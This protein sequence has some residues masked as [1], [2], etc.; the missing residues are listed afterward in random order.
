M[1][2]ICVH[3]QR[4]IQRDI[5]G[6]WATVVTNPSLQRNSPVVCPVNLT[7]HQTREEART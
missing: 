5:T 7:G 4:R 6:T 3:C 2:R 1:I